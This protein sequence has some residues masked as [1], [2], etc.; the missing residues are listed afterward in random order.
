MRAGSPPGPLSSA[1]DVDVRVDSSVQP[2]RI[3]AFRAAFTAQDRVCSAPHHVM[4]LPQSFCQ[5]IL[6]LDPG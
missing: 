2:D 3:A 6:L 4:E 1:S 5:S